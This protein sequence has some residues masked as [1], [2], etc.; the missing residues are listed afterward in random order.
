MGLGINS[1]TFMDKLYEDL[2]LTFE[3]KSLPLYTYPV[4][5]NKSYL[6]VEKG[7]FLSCVLFFMWYPS[8]CQIFDLNMGHVI[9][10]S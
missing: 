3:I 4:L 8:G 6:F 5:S 7:I 10:S 1:T 2:V 9:I